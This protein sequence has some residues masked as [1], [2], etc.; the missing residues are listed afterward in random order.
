MADVLLSL[1]GAVILTLILIAG[2]VL[3]NRHAIVGWAQE[4]RRRSYRVQ[5]AE[6]MPLQY[7]TQ[8]YI[9]A[10]TNA[11]VRAVLMRRLGVEQWARLLG[12]TMT[13]KDDW[14]ALYSDTW[15]SFR[16]V[17]VVNTTPSEDGTQ[18]HYWLRIP[19][20]RDIQPVRLCHV[21]GRDLAQM[22]ISKPREAVAWTF[23][24]CGDHY[25]PAMAS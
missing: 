22:V 16:A 23:S 9:R 6:R 8:S 24:L 17:E 13:N 7:V 3:I 12:V 11:E 21:C 5:L 14:G 1:V 18:K 2:V 10:E 20:T 25:Q 15:G 19:G 4:R